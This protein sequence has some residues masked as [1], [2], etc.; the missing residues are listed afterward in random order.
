MNV[1][2]L[3]AKAAGSPKLWQIAIHCDQRLA[4]GFFRILL[5]ATAMNIRTLTNSTGLRGLPSILAILAALG[6]A[7]CGGGGGGTAAPA[8]PPGPPPPP[9]PPPAFVPQTTFTN[10]S[11]MTGITH[12]FSIATLNTADPAQI[13]GG[14]AAADVDRDGDIDLYF[15]GGD[16]QPNAFYRN[17]GNNQFTDIAAAS[18][19]DVTHLGSGPAFAD[20]DAD[21]DLDLFVGAVE[22]DPIYLFRNDGGVFTDITANSGLLITADN[23]MSASFSDYDLDDDLDLIL[24]H[25]GHDPSPDTETIWQNNGDG[26]FVSTSIPSGIADQL[27][28]DAGLPGLFDY[29]FAPMMS[30]ID[31][32]GDPD[33]LF[34]SDFTTS[35]V[36]LNNGDETFTDI[37]DKD[38]IIDRNGMGSAA[39][40]YD[41]DGDMDWYVTSIFETDPGEDPNPG[42]RLYRNDGNGVF[43]DV[44][45]A[46]GVAD[47]GWGWAVCM[48]DFDNDGDLDIFHVNG[49]EQIDPRDAGGP[50]DYTFDQVRYFESQGDGTFV[51]A[52]EEAGLI[53]T[54]Q[55][56]GVAC[57]D[58]DRDGD[59]DLVITNNQ[60]LESVVVYRNDL[61]G[62][63]HYLAIKLNGAGLNSDAVGAMIEVSGGGRTQLREIRASNHFVSQNPA[64]A[65]FGLGSATSVDITISWPG[66]GQTILNGVA[67]DQYLVVDQ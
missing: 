48:E 45:D 47:G 41:N 33:I 50:N 51:E 58:S 17:D 64:E 53:D 39:G 38:V 44:T 46:A 5:F 55:G 21:G 15:V 67:A 57:F 28:T 30:D 37:T 63:R 3:C 12:S 27:I 42:N 34:A 2:D 31:R 25:W 32:D 10:V 4:S 1:S 61:A 56:R 54:G 43:E 7:A 23:T 9:P 52:A 65:H 62:N 26:T 60:D 14:L 35:K 11:A 49:W 20:I 36:F 59:L 6:T 19:L 8:P 29:T 22:G 24:A 13:G 16:G 40:D 66:G 18:A